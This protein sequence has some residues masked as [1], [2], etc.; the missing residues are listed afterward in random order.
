[1]NRLKIEK[2]V[3]VLSA[4]VEGSS[5]RSIER[6]TGVHRDTI[7]RL[8]VRAG[9]RCERLHLERVRNVIV[10]DVQADELWNF[11]YCKEK[12]KPLN[13]PPTIGD[14][15]CFVAI[16]RY[17]KLVLA[18]E[19][20]KRDRVTAE[21]FMSKLR[22]ATADDRFQ[23]TTDG[24]SAY[25]GAVDA[26]LIDRAD[27]AML[28][29]VYAKPSEEDQRRYS[30]GDV[31]NAV[32]IPI[33]GNPDPSRICTS[34]VERHNLTMRMQIRRLTRL[35]NAFSKKWTNLKAALGLYFCW[36]NFCRVHMSLR[37]TPAMEAGVT[38]HVWT[39]GELLHD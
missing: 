11:C 27:Y 29:K 36:Y 28:V 35:T 39:I 18:W 25:V 10:R 15:W 24:L 37:V 31:V 33:N 38:D 16:E 19:L 1:M 8:M 7:L 23:L 32:P 21:D 20:G 34:H 26:S 17:S 9:D 14:A 5:V 30:P 2:Q 12:N 13:A 4:L 6:M 3:T 22:D